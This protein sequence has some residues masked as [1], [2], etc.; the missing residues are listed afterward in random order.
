[1]K[2]NYIKQIFSIIAICIWII[3]SISCK[4]SQDQ[5]KTPTGSFKDIDGNVYKTVQIGDQVWMAENLKVAHY[6]N[7]DPIEYFSGGENWTNCKTGACCN[8]N[9]HPGND[10]TF[11][12]LYNGLAVAD[13]RNI[14][15]EGWHIPSTEEWETLIN[16]AGG[17][18]LAGGKLKAVDHISWIKPNVGATDEFGFSG[19][20][21][22]YCTFFSFF[23][24]EYYSG[25]WWSSTIS[26]E[27]FLDGFLVSNNSERI[28][29][30]NWYDKYGLSVRCV[31]D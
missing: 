22:G 31:K 14:A 18:S 1:M 24:E 27:N 20:P 11:G 12:K 30:S 29:H 4:K 19:L 16:Y 15:P 21:G 7:G 17:Y 2:R 9:N 28:M 26:K 8:Y 5:I 23:Y 3:L 13:S 25:L 6:R 10:V